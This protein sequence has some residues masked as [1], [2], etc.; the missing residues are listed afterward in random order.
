VQL[1]R[2]QLHEPH[3]HSLSPRALAIAGWTAFAVAG[4]LFLAIAWN[5]AE[6]DGIVALD[7]RV[8]EWLHAH[9]RPGLTAFLLAVTHLN[10]T[11]G[12]GVFSAAFAAVLARLREWT[13]MLTLALTVAG[14]MLLNL[15]LKQA[16][17]RLRPRFDDPLLVLET[18]S[19]PSGHT[20]AAV[21]FYGVLA[22]FLVSRF[23]DARRRAA[24][25]GGAIAAVAL[26]AF[27]RLYLGAHYL[28]DVV[29]A[30]CSSTAWLVLCLAFGHALVRGRLK[31]RWIA[32]AALGLAT[33]VMAVLLPLADWSDK[34]AAAIGG[35]GLAAGLGWFCLLNVVATLLLVPAWIF[36]LVAG[37][38]FGMPWGVAAAL[39]GA[40]ASALA[41]FLLARTVLRKPVERGARRFPA[42]KS[43]DKAVA[44][45]GW[46]VVALLRISPVL[47]SGVKSYLLG[48]TRVPL[49]DYLSASA[50][51]MLPGI[52]LKVYVGASGRGALSE[53]GALNWTLFA[54]GV[55]AT[56]I[57]TIWLGR[58]VRRRLAL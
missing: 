23:Y 2:P 28:S 11:V 47:P 46:K 53:G 14:A 36:P 27:S 32:L 45:G 4:S 57:L 41:A 55:A 35:M 30:V 48:L 54:A 24:C 39:G 13:W 1:H 37:A 19:F 7:A 20:A 8:A 18:Y 22:A 10:S 56:V 44:K 40:L 15:V 25:V 16:Y 38:V 43:V 6:P 9:G 29:G 26:V 33:L 52:L 51:G 31:P 42:F 21:A 50:A 5:L 34:L 49:T 3:P 12:I 17:E 58:A